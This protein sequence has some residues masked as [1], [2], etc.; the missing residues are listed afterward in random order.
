MFTVLARGRRAQFLM[1]VAED[2]AAWVK[3]LPGSISTT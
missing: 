1:S 3:Q 2:A